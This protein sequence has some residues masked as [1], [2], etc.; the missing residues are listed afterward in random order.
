MDVYEAVY[1]IDA[2]GSIGYTDPRKIQIS[3]HVKACGTAPVASQMQFFDRHLQ[4]KLGVTCLPSPSPKLMPSLSFPPTTHSSKAPD[5]LCLPAPAQLVSQI[6]Q[7][8]ARCR[9]GPIF[10]SSTVNTCDNQQLSCMAVSF[11][12][13][14]LSQ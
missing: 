8:E 7:T 9:Q 13:S 14:R 6:C 4:R 3:F 11:K 10:E 1:P 2:T 5:L 12:S